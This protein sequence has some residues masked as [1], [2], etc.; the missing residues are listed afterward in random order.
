MRKEAER[1]AAEADAEQS[2]SDLNSADHVFI[3]PDSLKKQDLEKKASD[4]KLAKKKSSRKSLKGSA[5]SSRSSSK[6]KIKGK[7]SRSSS[8]L[9]RKS[10]SDKNLENSDTEQAK[11]EKDTRIYKAYDL[12]SILSA[13]GNERK[14]FTSD[15]GR[16]RI[17]TVGFVNQGRVWILFGK[18]LGIFLEFFFFLFQNK[19]SDIFGQFLEKV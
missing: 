6:T 17:K 19:F 7:S 16:I 1:A 2:Q 8:K 4:K 5:K 14:I 13:S 9:S 10:S 15:G 18:I 12:G 3:M 11:E